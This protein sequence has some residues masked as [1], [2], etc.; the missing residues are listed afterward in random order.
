MQELLVIRLFVH[1]NVMGDE[2][3]SYLIPR[4]DL[5]VVCIDDIVLIF[6]PMVSF[7]AVPLVSIKVDDKKTAIVEPLFHVLCHESNVR[8]DA[9]AATIASCSMMVATGQVDG[10]AFLV[11]NTGSVNRA[12]RGSLHRVK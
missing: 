9:K 10:P 8:V 11:S 7:M 12:L 4:V 1:N 2:R 6:V 5:V 3:L